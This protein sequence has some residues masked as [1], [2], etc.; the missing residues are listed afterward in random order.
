MTSISVSNAAKN[1]QVLNNA[2]KQQGSWMADK[3][4]QTDGSFQSTMDLWKKP[5]GADLSGNLEEANSQIVKNNQQYNQKGTA[6]ECVKASATD[7]LKRGK[8][9]TEDE[10]DGMKEAEDEIVSQIAKELGVSEED[11]KAALESLGIHVFELGN[12]NQMSALFTEILGISDGMEIVTNEDLFA[13][14]TNLTQSVNDV[15]QS[16]Q[17][18]LQISMEDV[19]EQLE[20]QKYIL[21]ELP[22]EGA[23]NGTELRTDGEVMAGKNSEPLVDTMLSANAENSVIGDEADTEVVQPKEIA[24]EN[25]AG[26]HDMSGEAKH[27]ANSQSST[28]SESEHDNSNSYEDRQNLNQNPFSVLANPEQTL[29]VDGTETLRFSYSMV[30]DIMNQIGDYV[31]TNVTAD[32]KQME[33]QLT[34]ANLGHVHINIASKNGV[35]TAQIAAENEIVKNAIELQVVQ[36]KERLESQGVKIEAVEVTVASH[37]FERN[38]DGNNENRETNEDV[39][40]TSS[41]KWNLSEMDGDL[42][43]AESLSEAEQVELDMMKLA[44]NQLNYMV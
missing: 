27:I 43:E 25:D 7:N 6:R 12:A 44:G 33:I 38:L 15:I 5:A 20:A 28:F 23:V 4:F 26:S 21:E 30:D 31:K 8:S 39:K 3:N 34:P 2:R 42:L 40:K 9:F 19:L 41:K 10:L 37:E 24:V 35:I 14:L 29:G 36:L 1:V 13:S 17:E 32:V 22:T 18:E 16:L 11:V